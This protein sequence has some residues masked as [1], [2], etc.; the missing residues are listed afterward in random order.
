M[1]DVLLIFGKTQIIKTNMC[2]WKDYYETLKWPHCINWFSSPSVGIQYRGGTPLW[3]RVVVS[4]SLVFSCGVWG[5]SENKPR[6][7]NNNEMSLSHFDIKFSETL[8]NH[9]IV[10]ITF[11]FFYLYNAS[12]CWVY[13]SVIML[14]AGVWQ[15]MQFLLFTHSVLTRWIYKPL[16]RVEFLYGFCCFQSSF[17]TQKTEGK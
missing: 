8:T 3:W 10:H 12:L 1:I 4:M 2:F 7:A 5:L 6:L 17:H 14:S 15:A 11:F 9:A 13:I 16:V